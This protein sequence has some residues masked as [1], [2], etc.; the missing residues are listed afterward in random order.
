MKHK[1]YTPRFAAAI[2]SSSAS[3]AIIIPPSIPMII[4]GAMAD[5]SMVQLFVAGIVPGL[6]GGF[7]DGAVLV[8]GGALRSAARRAFQPPPASA[9]AREAP[10]G[11]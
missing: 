2:T 3:L 8:V 1:G 11:R 5:T 4:Y 10:P 6:L 7:S 9:T